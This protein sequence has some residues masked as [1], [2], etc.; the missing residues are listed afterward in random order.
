[1]IRTCGTR[2]CERTTHHQPLSACLYEV[3]DMSQVNLF[4]QKQCMHVVDV[5]LYDPP[6]SV[7]AIANHKPPFVS[8][9][10]M[11]R[12][13]TRVFLSTSLFHEQKIKLFFSGIE[14]MN[15]VPRIGKIYCSTECY[16]YDAPLSFIAIAK[17]KPPF[18]SGLIVRRI[19]TRVFLSTSLFG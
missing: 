10:R 15:C 9:L 19:L 7:I 8:G 12:I 13:L 3:P 5:I 17:H 2:T 6:L 14:R 4:T 18:V 1:M 16:K 11:R